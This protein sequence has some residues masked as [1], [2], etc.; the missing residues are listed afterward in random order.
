M[1]IL[2]VFLLSLL[3]Y[4]L[5][6]IFLTKKMFEKSNLKLPTI[7]LIIIPIY[8]FK[9]H[10]SI[11]IDWRHNRRKMIFA[12]LNFFLSYNISLIIFVEMLSYS[13]ENTTM[14]KKSNKKENKKF[15][16]LQVGKFFNTLGNTKKKYHDSLLEYCV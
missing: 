15:S 5:G 7:A 8:I 1:K 3:F 2:F 12:L 9:V 16:F 11:A 13:M 14:K 10:V 6:L 4:F